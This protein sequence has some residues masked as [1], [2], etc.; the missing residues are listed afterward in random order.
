[1]TEQNNNGALA[2]IRVLD[3]SRVLAGP[4]ATQNL[5]DL[6]AEVIKIE[7]PK[8]GDD[9]RAWGPPYLKNARSENTTEA[10]YY[11]ST[12]RGK[13]SVAVDITQT[14]GQHI[15]H[16]LAKTCDVV[17]E[18]FKVG[19]LKKYHLDYESLK[20]INPRLIY[21][22]ITGFGQTGPCADQAGY[23]F[24]IQGMSGLM[25]ITGE[26]DGNPMKVGVALTDIMTG[27]Y[28]TIAIEAALFHRE[29]TGVGQYIDVSLLD[30]QVATLANQAMN[31]LTTG[32][33]PTRLGNAHPNIVPYQA[34]ATQ[35]SHIIIAVGNDHQFEKFCVIANCGELA[36]DA[37]F[38]NNQLRVKNRNELIDLLIPLIKKQTT[39]WWLDKLETAHVPCGPI[40]T[41]EQALNH[42]QILHRHLVVDLPHPTAGK[43]TVVG[44]PIKFSETPITYYRPPPLLG[45][46]TD[47]VIDELKKNNSN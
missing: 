38:N 45:E 14:E 27:L 46:H 5:A 6:G 21:C 30:V 35:D 8:A 26:S 42:P 13:K 2:G 22:S 36:Q 12:N 47:S 20:T 29:K 23:D 18:N 16:E 44:N 1:M 19:G 15:I 34:F 25:S 39:A 37:R 11:L 32:V 3:L 10:A 9:T 7:N 4:W 17:I 28:A 41:I 43:V 40:N 24:M 33:S 31:Y